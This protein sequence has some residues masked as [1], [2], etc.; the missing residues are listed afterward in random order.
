MHDQVDLFEQAVVK[1]FTVETSVGRVF[2]ISTD[3]NR[4]VDTNKACQESPRH[5]AD[6]AGRADRLQHVSLQRP[7]N[8]H[9]PETK[10]QRIQ[11]IQR[12]LSKYRNRVCEICGLMTC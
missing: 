5:C 9:V 10:E 1:A 8:P 4:N 7:Y 6:V 12:R 2:F 11:R 3:K